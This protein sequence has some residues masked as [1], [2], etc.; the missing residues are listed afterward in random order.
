MGHPVPPI[1]RSV[2]IAQSKPAF[3]NR[4]IC[5]KLKPTIQELRIVKLAMGDGD[6]DR[7]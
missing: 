3:E 7:E 4:M 2:E 1:G 6:V 5:R